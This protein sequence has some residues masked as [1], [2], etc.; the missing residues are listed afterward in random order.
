MRANANR[1]PLLGTQYAPLEKYPLGHDPERATGCADNSAY[2]GV[3]TV[4]TTI[5]II[6]V[7]TKLMNGGIKVIDLSVVQ[8]SQTSRR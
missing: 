3:V 1:A 2:P 6:V 4:T 5:D 7:R 8:L